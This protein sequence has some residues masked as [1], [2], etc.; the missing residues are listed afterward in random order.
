MASTTI[1]IGPRKTPICEFNWLPWQR[2][3][4]DRQMNAGFVKL[5]IDH[6]AGE[7]IRLVASV[8]VCVCACVFV[9]LSVGTLLFELFDL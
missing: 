4:S 8:C 9:R 6:V 2:P 5:F 7:I 3:V 1:K